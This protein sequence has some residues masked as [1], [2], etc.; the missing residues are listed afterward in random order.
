[1]SKY[2]KRIYVTAIPVLSL[3]LISSIIALTKAYTYNKKINSRDFMETAFF[4]VKEAYALI[5][6]SE[7]Y[8]KT[9]II[10]LILTIALI[11]GILVGEYIGK[12]KKR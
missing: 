1:V 9:G 6:K 8:W 2:K 7:F 10:L 4:S 11:L 12:V 3:M 5:E